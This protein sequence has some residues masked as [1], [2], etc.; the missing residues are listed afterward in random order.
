MTVAT[1]A[2]T[3]VVSSIR[4]F[5]GGT[6]TVAAP[7]ARGTRGWRADF[8]QRYQPHKCAGPGAYQREC[9]FPTTFQRLERQT[10]TTET[11]I[12]KGIAQ[13]RCS[14]EI[15]AQMRHV[16]LFAS[17]S[18]TKRN[19]ALTTSCSSV[20][21]PGSLVKG[22]APSSD[23]R[24][25]TPWGRRAFLLLAY[26][27]SLVIASAALPATTQLADPATTASSSNQRN[28]K[29]SMHSGKSGLMMMYP[30]ITA[31]GM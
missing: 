29:S 25:W 22:P 2:E 20:A 8:R 21:G 24:P 19:P 17:C 12:E 3:A 13:E 14:E 27:N 26:F 28:P 15:P 16:L 23:A 1:N 7:L 5:G 30:G 6:I 11:I 31:P 10:N 4:G 9:R 18:S